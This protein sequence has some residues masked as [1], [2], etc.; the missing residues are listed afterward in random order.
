MRGFECAASLSLPNMHGALA[1]AIERGT[2]QALF[3]AFWG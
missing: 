2:K 3:E 1:T